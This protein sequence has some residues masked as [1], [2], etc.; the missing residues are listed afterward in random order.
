MEVRIDYKGVTYGYTPNSSGKGYWYC[1]KGRMPGHVSRSTA[2]MIAPM[3]LVSELTREAVRLNLMKADEF[4]PKQKTRKSVKTGKVK[5]KTDLK[6][7]FN[8]FMKSFT[9]QNKTA[10]EIEIEQALE[11]L[12]KNGKRRRAFEEEESTSFF[13]D[14]FNDDEDTASDEESESSEELVLEEVESEIIG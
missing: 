1:L 8:P 6:G 11:N 10:S 4:A 5:Y 2:Y 13:S 12:K 7:S 9:D 3:S 14:L